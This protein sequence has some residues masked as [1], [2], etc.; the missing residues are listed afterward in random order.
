SE[1]LYENL[2]L[3][4]NSD[5]PDTVY[6]QLDTKINSI[7]RSQAFVDY[8][9]SFRFADAMPD[10][11]YYS[12]HLA[13]DMDMTYGLENIDKP[14]YS[15]QSYSYSL[16]VSN[17]QNSTLTISDRDIHY[18]ESYEK[19]F[20][21]LENTTVSSTGQLSIQATTGIDLRPGTTIESGAI[22]DFSIR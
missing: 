19:D 15:S 20:V 10:D 6:K 8:S 9:H 13:L 18:P 3:L 16:Y 1:D 11:I 14:F 4:V 22:C 5:S 12:K 17:V 2:L 21:T 7:K